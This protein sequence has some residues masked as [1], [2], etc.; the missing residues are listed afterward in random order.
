MDKEQLRQAIASL[1]DDELRQ[2]ARWRYAPVM[3]LGGRILCVAADERAMND[4]RRAGLHVAW[5]ARPGEFLRLLQ[6]Q[7]DRLFADEAAN[8]LARRAPHMSAAWRFGRRQAWGFFI[9]ALLLAALGWLFPATVSTTLFILFSALFLAMAA[10]RIISLVSAPGYGKPPPLAD[11]ELPV[12]SILAPLYREER[13]LRQLVMALSRID[14]PAD[15]LDIKII[16]EEDD[17]LTREALAEMALPGHFEVMVT[18]PVGPRTKP[19]AMNYALAF[20]RGELVTIYDAEDIPDPGQLRRAADAFA[21]GGEDLACLQARLNWYNANENWLTRLF[22]IEYASHFSVIL[23]SLAAMGMPIP[24]GGTSNHFRADVLRACGGWDAHNV[25]E[26]A[27]LGFRL[28]RL[29]WRLGVIDSTTHEE[30]C[31]TI[32]D[33]SAQRARW[34]KGWLQTWLVH[35]RRPLAFARETGWGGMFVMHAMMGAGVFAALAH[36]FFL[37]WTVWRLWQPY[38]PPASVPEAAIAGIGAMVLV[39]GYGAAMLVGLA[40]LRRTGMWRLWP[41]VLAMPLY[42]LFIS[43]AA[44][45]ALWD[46]AVRPH[47]WRKTRHGVCAMLRGGGGK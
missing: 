31:S 6:D 33:W 28:A 24:L 8:G 2:A 30:A 29:G 38:A 16:V 39:A 43:A 5:R 47:H 1:D 13:V 18:P 26:D 17:K 41:N 34:I 3:G 40:G 7:A 21:A 25:T 14:Y 19:K 27:D 36:P 46:F 44:W 15:R 11:G 10:L 9:A 32:R 22:T 42:W 23:P 45:R 4:A 35:M 12:Y 37:L 20:A